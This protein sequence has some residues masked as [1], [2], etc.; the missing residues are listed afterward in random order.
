MGRGGKDGDGRGREGEGRQW[1]YFLS[2]MAFNRAAALLLLPLLAAVQSG[3]RL[4]FSPSSSG[5]IKH[6][7]YAG[8]EHIIWHRAHLLVRLCCQGAESQEAVLSV[9]THAGLLTYHRLHQKRLPLLALITTLTRTPRSP[10]SCSQLRC[11][12]LS[13]TGLP[14]TATLPHS[15]HHGHE[16][17]WVAFAD[18]DEYIFMPP[19]TRPGFLTRLLLRRPCAAQ[20][21]APGAAGRAGRGRREEGEA[22]QD[23]QQEATQLLLYNQFFIGYPRPPPARLT[24]ERFIHRPHRLPDHH[25]RLR[26]KMLLQPAAAL[27]GLSA[28]ASE[29]EREELEDGSVDDR[30]MQVIADVIKR[31]LRW[32]VPVLPVLCEREAVIGAM[33]EA[34]RLADVLLQSVQMENG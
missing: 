27:G 8:T 7:R 23:D 1:K 4:Q 22:Q 6:M 5:W 9:Y 17:K 26:G 18:V 13:L 21:S 19:D 28:N 20:H 30:S 10:T 15:Q 33:M 25:D 11:L 34:Q 24:I 3:V 29:R 16:S 32:V 2:A 14:S 12:V 31:R